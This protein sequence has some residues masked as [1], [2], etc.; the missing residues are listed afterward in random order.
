MIP[1]AAARI[2]R[3]KPEGFETLASTVT[4]QGSNNV[5]IALHFDATSNLALAQQIATYLNAEIAAGKLVTYVRCGSAAP[6][7]RERGLRPSN[8]RSGKTATRLH[9]GPRYET[10][11][12]DRLRFG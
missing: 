6:N 7:G 9:H 1:P 10:W 2:L 11:V 8:D 12:G 3:A 5:P 4:I